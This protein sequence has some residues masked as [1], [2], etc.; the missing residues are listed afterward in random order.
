MVFTS[1]KN[2]LALL[3]FVTHLLLCTST[4]VLE[5][6]SSWTRNEVEVRVK[7]DCAGNLRGGCLWEEEM[8]M[9][10]E[11]SRRI[12]AAQ[13]KYISY[14]ALKRDEVPCSK[15]GASYYNC[16]APPK[17]NN[18]YSRGCTVITGCARDTH[19]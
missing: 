10:S 19:Y 16:Q 2:P 6:Y 14:E 8:E 17:T 7:R 18:P 1:K 15:P 13:K 4:Q 9:D 3:L 11:I 12:L 5:P